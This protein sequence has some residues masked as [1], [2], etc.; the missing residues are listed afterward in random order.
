[1]SQP[2]CEE[3]ITAALAALNQLRADHQNLFDEITAVMEELRPG[4]GSVE[5]PG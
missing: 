5:T 4:S 1:M 3:R 2:T